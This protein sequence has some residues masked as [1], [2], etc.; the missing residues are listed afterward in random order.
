[1]KCPICLEDKPLQEH[2][3]HPIEYGGDPDGN[4][5]DLCASCHLSIH[6]TAEALTS[7]KGLK[8][9]YLNDDQL[10]RSQ[11]LIKKIISAKLT[12]NINPNNPRKIL[13]KNIPHSLLV[14]LHKRK[15]DRGFTNLEKYI[16]SLLEKDISIL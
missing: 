2:H 11:F 12:C 9:K 7:K 13:L 4:T 14:K 6:H 1:M 16:M 5:T 3:E 8:T 10:L 15:L